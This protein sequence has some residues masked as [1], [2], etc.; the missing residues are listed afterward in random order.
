MPQQVFDRVLSVRR[1]F[2]TN[3]GRQAALYKNARS[4]AVVEQLLVTLQLNPVS[5]PI[6]TF[7]VKGTT[8]VVDGGRAEFF[9]HGPLS[10]MDSNRHSKLF[11]ALYSP[12][13]SQQRV[14]SFI[15]SDIKPYDTG[16]FSN[17]FLR[18]LR[19]VSAMLG[20]I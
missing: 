10:C 2:P 4:E 6:H 11:G 16:S 19:H 20:R 12:H 7:R 9:V 14:I 17:K 1:Y 18:Q 8:Q 15:P 13:H 5:N 3:V